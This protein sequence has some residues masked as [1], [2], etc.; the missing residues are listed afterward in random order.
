MTMSSSHTPILEI[1]NVNKHFG[2]VQALCSVNMDIYPGEVVGLVGDNGAGK[3][4]LVKCI[5]GIYP[6]D[7]GKIFFE[8]MPVDIHSPKDAM[9]LGIQTVYQ[10][11]ALCENIDVV[12]N[13]FL[14]KEKAKNNVLDEIIMEKRSIEILKKL[15]VSLPSVR[16]IIS[17]L[18]SGQRQS[19]AIART[20]ISDSKIVILDEPTAALGV[21]QSKQVL[22]I[23][24][25]LS[26]QG[27]AVLVI[28]HNLTH[29]FEI[30]ERIFVLRLGRNQGVFSRHTSPE[31]VLSA[32][33]G[34][35][36]TSIVECL[37]T[38]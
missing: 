22:D 17:N 29:I 23:I 12:A 9:H 10:D 4:T 8:G 32:I 16:H 15:A 20:L 19:V 34:S 13:M 33:T 14:G 36:N 18:S 26:S 35:N 38:S 24:K 25:K 11:L 2:A 6:I 28:S 3:S 30:V 37:S 31:Q 1:K 7:S 21:A 27:L 5:A